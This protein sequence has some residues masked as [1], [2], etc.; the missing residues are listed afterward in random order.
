[1][2]TDEQLIKELEQAIAGLLFMSESDYPFQTFLWKDNVE[3]TEGYLRELAGKGVDAPV[4][5][6]SVDEF[7]R[8]AVSEPDWKGAE[9]IAVAKR[10]QALV[11]WLKENLSNLKVYRVGEIDIQ[12]YIQGSSGS[13]SWIGI[14]TRV[15]ET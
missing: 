9:E 4:T 8:A 10:Y 6:Q 2:K 12:V 15:I 13:G 11:G 3:V 1:M 5:A 14:S 7:F